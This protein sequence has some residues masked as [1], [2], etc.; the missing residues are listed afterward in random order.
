VSRRGRCLTPAIGSEGLFHEVGTEDEHGAVVAAVGRMA[1]AVVV[2]RA[3]QDSRGRVGDGGAGAAM[4]DEDAS[5]RHDHLRHV[6]PFLLAAAGARRA[7]RD[8]P[9]PDEVTLEEL[10]GAALGHTEIE[11][12][13]WLR[14]ECRYLRAFRSR[15]AVWRRDRANAGRERGRR[16]GG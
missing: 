11:A 1:E 9:H 15:C 14:A 13:A 8:V 12:E 4:E 6:G 5:S 16:R 2:A 7:A 10:L 3:E